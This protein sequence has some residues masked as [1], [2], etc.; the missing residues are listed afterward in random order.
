M[1]FR[2]GMMDSMKI[3]KETMQ[4]VFKTI[5]LKHG[6]SDSDAAE[7]AAIFVQNSLDGVYSHGV[8]RFPRVVE[9][10]KK[11]YIDPNALIEV[12]GSFGCI[13]RWNANLGMGNLTAKKAMKR[14][15]ELAAFHGM[16]CVAVRNTNHWMRGGT[17]GWQAAEAGCIGMCFTNTLP[18][19]PAWGARN[20]RI[21]NNPFV[22]AIPRANGEH[23]VVDMAMAQY[24]YGKIEEARLADRQLPYPGGYDSDG[25]LTTDPKA[26][27][28]T[29]RVLPIGYWKGSSLALVLD[30]VTSVLSGG[31]STQAI[32]KLCEDEIA[33]SQ[34]FIA[35]DPYRLGTREE[36]ERILEG[37]IEDLKRSEPID[38]D[39]PVFYPGERTIATRR[40]NTKDGIPVTPGV[41]QAIMALR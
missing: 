9:Y 4:D 19:M 30:A 32:G 24:S 23:I 17:Y 36:A 26:I 3:S 1:F 22:L 13:E 21:G 27:E 28:E 40:I 20:G 15:I 8:N 41:W 39:I 6:F 2:C 5:L 37:I 35:I 38:P 34:T 11:G 18:N 16:G 25:N 12:E 33:I 14:A 10:L 31:N 29:G 7:S